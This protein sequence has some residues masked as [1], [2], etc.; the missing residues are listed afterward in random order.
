MFQWLM[1]NCL[2]E[3]NLTYAL[4][5]L[6]N[7]IVYL[8]MEDDHLIQLRAILER[9]QEYRLKL[10]PS[11]CNFFCTEIN[12]LGHKVSVKGMQPG[13]KGLRGIA[14]IVPPTT[15][16]EVRKFVGATRFLYQFIKN[17]AR[18]AKPLNDLLEGENS[19]L[20]L[21]LEEPLKS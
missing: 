12:Y 21:P 13:T 1:Q 17:Y 8:H 18:I 14:E 10:K 20:N 16:T 7:V 9:F 4:I 19:K 2:G 6:D 5:Y 3:L 11:K 15:Y